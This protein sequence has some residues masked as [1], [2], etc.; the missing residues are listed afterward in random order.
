MKVLTLFDHDAAFCP[1]TLNFQKCVVGTGYR[2]H[3]HRVD[4]L[5]NLERLLLCYV[6][7]CKAVFN[8][9]IKRVRDQSPLSQKMKS[10]LSGCEGAN[11]MH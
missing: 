3:I 4:F 8:G 2:N 11:D 6:H 7:I 10:H 1:R 5:C 9:S